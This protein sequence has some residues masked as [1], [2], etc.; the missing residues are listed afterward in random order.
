MPLID[1]RPSR[2]R[3]E[4]LEDRTTPVKLT[5][6]SYGG[7]VSG[8]I[9]GTINYLGDLLSI[10]E[11]GEGEPESA[12]LGLNAEGLFY[13][14]TPGHGAQTQARGGFSLNPSG[15]N[16]SVYVDA[17]AGSG[18]VSENPGYSRNLTVRS[19]FSG[20][21]MLRIDPE[22]GEQPEDLVD[23]YFTIDVNGTPTFSVGGLTSEGSHTVRAAI[24]DVFPVTFADTLVLPVT[25][26]EVGPD[27][28]SSFGFGVYGILAPGNV[29]GVTAAG[30]G[31]AGADDPDD[32][33]FGTYL[34]GVRY[35]NEFTVT[36]EGSHVKSVKVEIGDRPPIVRPVDATG[37]ARFTIDV[38]GLTDHHTHFFV[39]P[40]NA[41]GLELGS[42]YHGTLLI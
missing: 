5:W 15:G 18:F 22:E 11:P 26:P 21:G 28:T 2:L 27:K 23:L 37:T 31:L 42:P 4:P 41:G 6:V 40:L 17:W 14:S 12:P 39:T 34:P 20:S 19:A 13:E 16:A 35:D 3:L 30:D 33:L 1:R 7:T 9:G 29:L 8:S 36:T 32:V 10:S 38:G 25:D 24:G